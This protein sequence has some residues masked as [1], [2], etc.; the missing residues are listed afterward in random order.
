MLAASARGTK[1]TRR[2]SACARRAVSLDR[3]PSLADDR[4]EIASLYAF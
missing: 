4:L 1:D 2:G 3:A